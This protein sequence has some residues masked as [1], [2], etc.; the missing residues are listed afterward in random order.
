MSPAF[1]FASFAAAS[2][3]LIAAQS[4][5]TQEPEDWEG[6]ELFEVQQAERVE[7]D[8]L[9]KLLDRVAPKAFSEK[10]RPSA[11]RAV[12]G[13]PRGG[14][15]VPVTLI[16]LPLSAPFEGGWLAS[17]ID[18]KSDVRA[19]DVFGHADLSK[20]DFT[21]W[22]TFLLQFLSNPSMGTEEFRLE[23]LSAGTPRSFEDFLSAS[24]A[25]GRDM[26]E[27]FGRQ[28][29]LMKRNRLL[30]FHLQQTIRS[31]ETVDPTW[32]ADQRAELVALGEQSDVLKP[33]I[34]A[35]ALN[36]YRSG[37]EA[38]GTVLGAL[39]AS[40]KEGTLSAETFPTRARE[41][42]ASCKACHEVS[43]PSEDLSLQSYLGDKRRS[44]GLPRGLVE[45][46]YD[47]ALAP[48]LST[49][50]GKSATSALRVALQLHAELQEL[51]KSER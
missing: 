1:T 38:L 50:A 12:I 40:A 36:E 30:L 33:L 15:P 18:D 21:K 39:Y 19:A 48:G 49:A 3:M 17:A 43:S 37:A 4:F 42:S 47:V 46:G 10:N 41:L 20:E 35:K 5:P 26:I 9:D 28:R 7:E 44:A 2:V 11:Y 25:K 16:V 29:N 6:I 13:D 23:P 31:G 27:F 34:G 14:G 45:I 51:T 22:Y 24:D 8:V 32:F